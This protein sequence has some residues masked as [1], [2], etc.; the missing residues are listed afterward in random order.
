MLGLW[1][2]RKE[3]LGKKHR[4]SHFGFRIVDFGFI[5]H[6]F[7]NPHFAIYNPQFQWPAPFM[8]WKLPHGFFTEG[9][10]L[11]AWHPVEGPFSGA[12]FNPV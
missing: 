11:W 3:L 9:P 4:P 8:K 1:V 2:G 5:E 7:F 12:L 10:C 6:L